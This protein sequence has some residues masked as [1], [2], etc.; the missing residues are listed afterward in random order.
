MDGRPPPSQGAAHTF[1]MKCG[2]VRLPQIRIISGDELCAY[3]E[4]HPAEL[5]DWPLAP[6]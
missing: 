2:A 3:S 1:L 6:A 4:V 5:I